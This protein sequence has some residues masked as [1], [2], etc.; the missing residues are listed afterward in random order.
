MSNPDSFN[1]KLWVKI[2]NKLELSQS[3]DEV[4]KELAV[5]ADQLLEVKY[6][7]GLNLKLFME[8]QRLP[9]NLGIFKLFLGVTDT[10]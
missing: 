9:E 2:L 7:I 5:L 6:R 8:I 3:N 1:L 4:F 10:R